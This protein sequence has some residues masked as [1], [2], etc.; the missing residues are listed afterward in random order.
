MSQP[1][2]QQALYGYEEAAAS[3]RTPAGRC[4]LAPSD[5]SG[6]CVCVCVTLGVI[7]MLLHLFILQQ[8]VPGMHTGLAPTKTPV[9][10]L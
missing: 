3:V 8:G 7:G 2:S 4:Q 6:G 1:A 10:H 5:C 9:L